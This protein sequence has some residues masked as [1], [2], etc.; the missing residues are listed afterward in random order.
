[1]NIPQAVPLAIRV[2]ICSYDSWGKTAGG[3]AS[4]R[5]RR[6]AGAVFFRSGDKGAEPVSERS[7]SPL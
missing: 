3:I 1:M 4:A 2:E 7:S 5:A 6:W